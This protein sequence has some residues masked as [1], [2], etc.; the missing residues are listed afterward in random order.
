MGSWLVCIGT[1]CELDGGNGEEYA[2]QGREGG[3]CDKL[4]DGN[5]EECAFQGRGG[6]GCDK[7]DDDDGERGA[8]Q[9]RGREGGFAVGELTFHGA[10]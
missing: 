7:L 10:C 6:G 8:F 9:G 1:E 5:E 2:F 3:G 4:D